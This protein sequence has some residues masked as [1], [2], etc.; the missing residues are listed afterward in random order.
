MNAAFLVLGSRSSLVYGL[1]WC[2]A[3]PG[4]W[5]YL[6]YGPTWCLASRSYLATT[7]SYLAGDVPARLPGPAG[8][9]GSGRRS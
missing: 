2:I 9:A 3:L 7:W 4:A 5:S 6:V 1:T 8:V